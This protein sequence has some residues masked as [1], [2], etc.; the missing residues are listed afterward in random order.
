MPPV[1]SDL[2]SDSSSAPA[3]SRGAMELLCE[4]DLQSS[5][6]KRSL[7]CQIECISS[8][9]HRIPLWL[10]V[11]GMT[12]VF[13]ISTARRTAIELVRKSCMN[14]LEAHNGI[15]LTEATDIL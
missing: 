11:A 9:V 5:F 14:L 12:F 6:K 4:E 13:I 1:L 8:A 3:K 7:G 2:D 15:L 10:A